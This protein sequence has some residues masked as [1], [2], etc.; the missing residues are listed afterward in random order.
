MRVLEAVRQCR[1]AETCRI[2]QVSTSE[3]YGKVEEVPQN[4]NT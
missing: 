1:L 3:L 2:Y 4:E